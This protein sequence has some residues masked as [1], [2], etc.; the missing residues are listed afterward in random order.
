[1]CSSLTGLCLVFF[2]RRIRRTAESDYYFR[3]VCLSTWNDST[4]AERTF[5]LITCRKSVKN[6][7]WLN[8]TR[9]TG[10][11]H[12]DIFTFT[13]IFCWI[14]LIIRNISDKSCIRNESTYFIFKNVLPKIVSFMTQ[15]GKIR[16]IRTG[17]TWQYNTAH[18]HWMLDN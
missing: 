1:M 2:F 13:I 5:Y 9:I 17:H 4:P 15:C 16:Y 10:T 18:A 3:H 12:G 7:F 8:L 14:L 11:S 6:Q